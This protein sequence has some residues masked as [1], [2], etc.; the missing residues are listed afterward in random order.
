MAPYCFSL[1]CLFIQRK[2]KPL[3]NEGL[4]KGIRRLFFGEHKAVLF[5]QRDGRLLFVG[6]PQVGGRIVSF[7]EKFHIQV[8]EFFTQA[9]AAAYGVQQKVTQ[10][11]SVF[12]AMH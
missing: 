1:P 4:A 2:I 7:P 12:R 10:L 8:H 6:C 11:G 5:V 3:F 9:Y